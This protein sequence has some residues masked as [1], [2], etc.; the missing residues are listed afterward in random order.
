MKELA[1]D[2]LPVLA[3]HGFLLETQDHRS[4]TYVREDLTA[5]WDLRAGSIY[6]WIDRGED[7][8]GARVSYVGEARTIEELQ[9][10]LGAAS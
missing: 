3:Q 7:R 1:V 8:N 10:I 9:D 6:V 4:R 5:T 2:F